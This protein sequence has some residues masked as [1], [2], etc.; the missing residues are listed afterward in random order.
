MAAAAEL[1]L[2]LSLKWAV[3]PSFIYIR[4]NEQNALVL[5]Q[6]LQYVQLRRARSDQKDRSG[7]R[8]DHLEPDHEVC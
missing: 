8:K 6:S 7:P 3:I 1:K 4:I 2:L 5:L